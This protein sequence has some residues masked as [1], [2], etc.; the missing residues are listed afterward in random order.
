MKNKRKEEDPNQ[1][2]I[3]HSNSPANLTNVDLEAIQIQLQEREKELHCHNM[4]AKWLADPSLS[5]EV[6][7]QNL[8][9][10][11]P[12]SWQFPEITCARIQVNELEFTS[13]QFAPSAWML[14]HSILSNSLLIG[15]IQVCLC[16][17]PL[18]PA[19][20]FLQEES[21]LLFS[22]AERIAL[23]Y[24]R[25]LTENELNASHLKYKN[26][27]ENIN[28]I[29]F[30]VDNQGI[31]KYIS[32]GIKSVLGYSSS[33]LIGKPIWNF[34]GDNTD[35]MKERFLNHSSGIANSNELHIHSKTG[36]VRWLSISSR[37]V[38][39]NQRFEGITGT[40][41]DITER[42]QI[43]MELQRSQVLFQ[44]IL[45][46]SPDVITLTDLEGKILFASNK[47][48]ELFGYDS[49]YDFIGQSLFD[50]IHPD[51]HS[52][53]TSEIQLMFQ[54]FRE[55]PEEYN[56]LKFDGSL[57]PIEVNGQIIRNKAGIPE[58]LIFVTREISERK[59][60]L[61]ELQH[62]KEVFQQ[63]VET[64]NDVIYE[65]GLDGIIQ[66]VSPAIVKIL[67]YTSE[68]LIGTNFFEIMHPDDVP[69]LQQ[70]LVKL[71]D[72]NYSFLNYRYLCK[73]GDI[74]WVRSSTNPI[75]KDG[76]LIG[77][78]GSLTDIHD[79]K[80]TDLELER[81]KER[82]ENLVNTQTNY[83][84]RT[85]MEGYFTY[86][87]NKYHA[88]F[89]HLHPGGILN[90][91]SLKSV[92]TYHQE[93]AQETVYRCI[94]N[95]GEIIKIELD[96]IGKDGN[97]VTTF[98]E[99][100][101]L[102][103]SAGKPTEIQCMG[104]DI[105]DKKRQQ[106]KLIASELKY[107]ALFFDSPDAYLVL[108]D[109]IFIDCNRSA[110]V[111]LAG[112]KEDIIGKRPEQ[113]SPGFQ[114]NGKTS[115]EY[116]TEIIAKAYR[117]GFATFEWVHHRM[118]GN[119]FLAK[120]DLAVM[121]LDNQKVLFTTWKD[122]TK[123]REAELHI[124]KLSQA[125]EQNPLSIVITNLH[126]EIEYANPAASLITGYK[127]HELIG[128]NPRVLQSGDTSPEDYAKLWATITR[129][130]VW[131]G[132]FHN[133]KKS[134]ELYWESSTIAPIQDKS[135]KITHFV[136]L[137][138]DIT[139]KKLAEEELLKFRT[140]SDKATY[141]TAIN[142]LNG[143]FI[144]VNEAW[145]KMHGYSAEELVG[146]NIAI[147]HNAN[148]QIEAEQKIKNLFVQGEIPAFELGQTRKDGSTFP[149]LM[150]AS[151]VSDENKKPL[152]LSAT[153]TDITELKAKEE[154]IRISE[155]KL[156]EAQ[157]IAKMGSWEL[158]FN[159]NRIQWSENL[160]HLF[161]LEPF[162]GLTNDDFMQMIH[163]N[164]K[165]KMGKAMDYILANK[166]GTSI[167]IRVKMQDKNYIWIRNEVNP[168]YKD[169]ELAGLMGVY[170]DITEA[171]INAEKLQEQYR[172]LN[173]V[174]EA[175]PDLIFQLDKEGKYLDFYASQSSKGKLLTAE[176]FIGTYLHEWFD[177]ETTNLHIDHINTSLQK[178]ELVNYEYSIVFDG[179]NSFFESRLVPMSSDHVIAFVR[180]IT[181]KK[182]AENEI[183]KLSMAVVQSPVLIIITDT[184]GNIEYVNPAFEKV[185]GYGAGEILGKNARFLKSGK[186]PPEVYQDLW[187]TI[188]KGKGWEHEWTNKKK[189]GEL[190]WEHVAINPIFDAK[191]NIINY[192]AIKQD[193]TERKNSELEIIELNQNLEQKINERTAELAESNNNLQKEILDRMKSEDA[194]R[195]KT[196][197]LENF[198]NVALDLLCIADING[199]FIK[200]NKA[201]ERVLGY[202]IEELETR[203]FLD[204]VH[205]VDMQATLDAMATLSD[206]NPILGFTNRYK[207]NFGTYRYIEWR[208]TPVGN[209]IYAA[210]RDITERIHS[211]EEI[212]LARQEAETANKA[213]SEFLA[214]M[215][216]EIRT[217][218]NAILGYSE[219]LSS[220]IQDKTQQEFLS[221]IKSSGESLLTLI[222]DIL[223]LSKIE[224]GKLEL[225]FEYTET[226]KFF[227]EFE[228]IFA[229]KINERN[230]R[231]TTVI[232]SGT[233]AFLYIDETRLRQIILNLVGNAVKF[234]QDGDVTLKVSIKNP[235]IIKNKGE[236]IDEV[237]DLE[238]QVIDTGIGIPAQYLK[239]IFNSFVQV[240]SKSNKGGT[241][242]GLPITKKLVRLM[243]GHI[244]VQSE[245]G[246]GS[247]FTV[248][249]PDI[250]FLRSFENRLSDSNFFPTDIQ[251]A[252]ARVL[253]VDDIEENRRFIIDALRQTS[254][255]V[256]EASGGI[257]AIRYMTINMPDLIITDIR[258]PDMDGFEL[259]EQ[260][261]GNKR[262]RHIPVIA[263]SASVMKDQKER[264]H[265]SEFADLLIKPVQISALYHSLMKNLK[266]VDLGEIERP[267]QS[268]SM[269]DIILDKDELVEILEG[270]MSLIHKSLATRQPIHEVVLFGTKLA[271]LGEKHHCSIISDYGNKLIQAAKNFNIEGILTFL[272]QY[273]T[274]IQNLK[275]NL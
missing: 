247:I 162:T 10:I 262:L 35:S 151:I 271:D 209:K 113:L 58:R 63:M 127:Y 37:S 245:E 265:H 273:P 17:A 30:E 70:A 75:Y 153:C 230:I 143:D 83:V 226:A 57:F 13:G 91:Y 3:Q 94:Q 172:K 218:M 161:G 269:S 204:F 150:S 229:F 135:G 267:Y 158:D 190:F 263:Y 132:L 270:E 36:G 4:M 140:I 64:I 225:E 120:V 101:C 121:N 194:L 236:S 71:G 6:F 256:D 32:P 9:D 258:M 131:K 124:L 51:D 87:N 224:A 98:W 178:Q 195:E 145:A 72:V 174:I 192:L 14:E 203:N 260:V 149:S 238:I 84:V 119:E 108:Y 133:K 214:S 11:I 235:Q 53:A 97:P 33:E 48:Y 169:E 45:S 241:G 2:S 167:E 191:G 197:E 69:I 28:E 81:N 210:A 102:T 166:T 163:P 275:S 47:A 65:V 68:E 176:N 175:T 217:P 12:I 144:Y 182:E 46:A 154:A 207:T 110:E 114:P 233:P 216:H 26:L 123:Q 185:T 213:K 157:R 259:L 248:L 198:F 86:V 261:K 253:V 8:A 252:P 55:K 196:I 99:F 93:I 130:E 272:T 125:I 66:Y 128:K 146:Q 168:I 19:I 142:N 221:S 243:H 141:G 118:D 188:S 29:I 60:V 90:A 219:L 16:E 240:R 201:W 228:R 5:F 212:K 23:V 173:A 107:R 211:E 170:I 85:D 137:K 112:T 82:L 189:N 180:D 104:F 234:T 134:G 49:S 80:M 79:Q 106:E 220:L 257:A 274:M 244:S 155:L 56:G 164:D 109:G 25:N 27:V 179:K 43:E 40:L 20:P 200:L 193:I 171:K 122:I 103:D 231:F 92:C 254:L 136:A 181:E 111:M 227:H 237:V 21:N 1:T 205:P 239:E 15:K 183:S 232:A 31:V 147:C 246:K 44:S 148:Q 50:F 139:S 184:E 177:E 115:V 62:S 42:K 222:N 105:T 39:I 223:D 34:A 88:D 96:K 255:I 77:G 126:G 268:D 24:E 54:E 76:K 249:I 117:F 73:N 186:N 89:S 38:F 160:Y 242:L 215:S 22:I 74:H 129:G 159:T 208:S 18:P 165:P 78:R 264:I 59:R 187:N 152:F 266:Y 206:Q 116:A 138:E 251:F 202:S 41:T 52:K 95:P 250:P 100:V 199:N 61:E 156:N 7:L 67:G